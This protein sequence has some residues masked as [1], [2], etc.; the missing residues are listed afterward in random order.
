MGFSSGTFST[1]R[2]FGFIRGGPEF[3]WGSEGIRMREFS[4]IG[5]P[6]GS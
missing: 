5:L 6:R 3:V 2:Q 1:R 4:L